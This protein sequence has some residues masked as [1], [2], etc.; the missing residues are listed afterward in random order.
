MSFP[1]QPIKIIRSTGTS[2]SSITSIGCSTEWRAQEGASGADAELV[3][4][5]GELVTLGFVGF[6]NGGGGNAIKGFTLLGS[7]DPS[8]TW[9]QLIESEL[10]NKNSQ[11]ITSCH[12]PYDN[13]NSTQFNQN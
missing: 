10:K 1:P 4:D 6:R 11:V 8:D 7:K 12:N 9:T 2:S 5:L 3:I 13:I